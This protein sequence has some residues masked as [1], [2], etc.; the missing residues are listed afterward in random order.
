MAGDGSPSGHPVG[1]WATQER[2][3]AQLQDQLQLRYD[4]GGWNSWVCRFA[5]TKDVHG[6]IDVATWT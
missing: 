4:L 5:G 6:E 3:F 2:V 1:R